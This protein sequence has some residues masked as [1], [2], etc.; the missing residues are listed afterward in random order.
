M[1]KCWYC[2]CDAAELDED[3]ICGCV[4][5]IVP[6]SMQEEQNEDDELLNQE[7]E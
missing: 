6:K 5:Q 2:E 1:A 4:G 3:G 7:E